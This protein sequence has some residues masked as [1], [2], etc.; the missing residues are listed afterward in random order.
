MHW[1]KIKEE[2]SI[3]VRFFWDSKGEKDSKT[4]LRKKTL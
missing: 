1:K 3:D 2:N 4:Y